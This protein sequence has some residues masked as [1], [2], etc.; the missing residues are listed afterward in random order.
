VR[1]HVLQ[2]VE[3]ALHVV[4]YE[5]AADG[6]DGDTGASADEGVLPASL[7]VRLVEAGLATVDKRRERFL[8]PLVSTMLCPTPPDAAA[9]IFPPR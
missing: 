4:L 9:V 2:R 5:A 6:D 1:A 7:N 8:Q 3:K